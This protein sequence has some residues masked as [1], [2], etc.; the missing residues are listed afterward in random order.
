MSILYCCCY[1]SLQKIIKK[2]EPAY[3]K[4]VRVTDTFMKSARRHARKINLRYTLRIE[5]EI[6]VKISDRLITLFNIWILNSKSFA[7]NLPFNSTLTFT[8]LGIV[9]V[10][11]DATSQL[12]IIY[13]AFINYLRKNGNKVGQCFTYL[14]TSRKPVI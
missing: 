12:L 14:Y 1:R 10:D 4:H 13:S 11:F 8:L 7:F 9:G 6:T 5:T 2:V 3:T